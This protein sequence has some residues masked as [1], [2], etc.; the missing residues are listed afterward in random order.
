LAEM[1]EWSACLGSVF[2]KVVKLICEQT[3]PEITK[4]YMFHIMNEKDIAKRHTEELG[5]LLIHLIPK[6]TLSWLCH[7][8]VPL[9]RALRDAGLDSKSFAKIRDA[10]V[11]LGCNE[12]L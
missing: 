9:A 4:S 11:V 2:N 1:I 6:M 10:L 3:A 12:T 7:D 5:K 8:L